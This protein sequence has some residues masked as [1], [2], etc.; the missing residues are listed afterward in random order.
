MKTI[1]FGS[2]FPSGATAVPNEFIDKYMLHANGEYV[3]IYLYFLRLYSD[4]S[5]D[6]TYSGVIDLLEST[7]KD[8]RRALNY[9]VKQGLLECVFDADKDLESI[10]F[11]DPG[12]EE[13]AAESTSE[14]ASAKVPEK[15][16][17]SSSSGTL[18]SEKENS[19]NAS[20]SRERLRVLGKSEEAQNI[21]YIA[22]QYLSHTLSGQEIEMIL[23]FFDEK[24]FSVDLL[25]YLLDYCV[26]NGHK[27]WKYIQ[28]VAFA[29]DKAGI[30]SVEKAREHTKNH[31]KD[32]YAIM[33]AYGLGNRNPG[34]GEMEMI[35][36]WLNEYPL[37]TDLILEAVARTMDQ[38]HE[39][40]MRYTD[41]I[42][43]AWIKKG[44]TSKSD[45]AALD[46][47]HSGRKKAS[48]SSKKN[49]VSSG[50]GC[51]FDALEQLFVNKD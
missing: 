43:K 20:L 31:N 39:P 27:N 42:L 44:V 33:K 18:P 32:L 46:A 12:A 3:K 51:D 47:A 21:L 35:D 26:S 37:S 49:T 1:R 38:I 15:A 25:D 2:R 11:L 48:S 29:W 22:E 13:K 40:S 28:A 45:L 10:T 17:G 7:S 34:A 23:Y 4:G 19:R 41:S 14:T 16:D 24:H 5:R 36:S 9:W 50:S 6:W 8:V 30:D